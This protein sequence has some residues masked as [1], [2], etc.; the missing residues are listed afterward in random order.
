[1]VR[2]AVDATPVLGRPTG[3]GVAVGGLLESLRVLA[4]PS[5]DIV[6]YGLTARGWRE[7]R[8]RFPTGQV[9]RG[10]MPAGALQRVWG[11]V[12]LPPIELWTGAVDLVHGTNFVVPPARRAARLVSV[13]DLTAVRWPQMVAP[14]ALRYPGL[15][16]RAVAGGADVHTGAHAMVPEICETF[17]LSA[18]RVHVVGWG[19]KPPGPARPGTRPRLTPPGLTPPGPPYVLGLGTIEPRKDF[20]LLVAAF[21]RIADDHPDLQ[22][23]IVGSS[24]WGA[25]DLDD[26]IRRSPHAGRIRRDG[27]V[28]DVDAVIAGATV[29]AFPSVYEGFGVPPLEAM[30]HGVP[31]VATAAGAVPE[32]VGDA[33]DLVPVG[34]ADA[35]AAA[36][37]RVLDD[38][39]HRRRLVAAGRERVKDFTWERTATAMRDLYKEL[40]G[41]H[42]GR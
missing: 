37:G 33:A 24:G 5:L 16:R 13:H 10:P 30:A 25:E 32:V 40:A 21:D 39:E 14:A 17:G 19:I 8:R 7:L 3:I 29:F 34:D 1:M 28:D 4:D 27:W 20:P 22:L 26:A 36:I 12:E 6:T 42:T 18:E 23:R 11:Q 2:V 31:V 35:L 38:D 9:S 41:R 15:V